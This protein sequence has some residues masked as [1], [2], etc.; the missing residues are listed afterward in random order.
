MNHNSSS[1][2]K[3]KKIEEVKIF[4]HVDQ[5]EFEEAIELIDLEIRHLPLSLRPLG[6]CVGDN[7]HLLHRAAMRGGYDLLKYLLDGK[8]DVN[9]KGEV[10][11]LF[12]FCGK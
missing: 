5:K 7:C 9:L 11:A 10:L 6:N 8:A 12:V 1:M 2:L 4:E 3:R